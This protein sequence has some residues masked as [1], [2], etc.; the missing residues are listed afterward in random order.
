MNP[1]PF[2]EQTVVIAEDQDEYLNLPA[3]ILDNPQRETISCWHATVL[4][5]LRIL[6]TGKVW[7]G[8]W[9]FGHPLQPLM[10]FA[11]KPFKEVKQS[12][13][14]ERQGRPDNV[15]DFPSSPRRDLH[16]PPPPDHHLS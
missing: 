1:I 4:E 5:R 2:K 6:F 7:L 15:I 3:L 9:T 16:T 8:V 11:R 14:E 13:D 12:R 10:M